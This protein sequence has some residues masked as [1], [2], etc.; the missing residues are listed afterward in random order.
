MNTNKFQAYCKANFLK[1]PDEETYNFQF[2]TGDIDRHMLLNVADDRMD[3]F[4]AKYY[5]FKVQ[6]GQKSM[7]LERP[8]PEFNILKI[9]IDLHHNPTPDD[10]R[11]GQLEHRY[12]HEMIKELATLYLQAVAELAPIPEGAKITVFE[13][14]HPRMK[15]KDGEKKMIKDGIHI[16]SGDIVG[17]N[18]LL[19][20]VYDRFIAMPEL[21]EVYKKFGNSESLENMVDRKVIS[22]TAWFPIGSGK[23]DD[24]SDFY[25]PTTTYSIRVMEG[26]EDEDLEDEPVKVILR[27]CELGMDMQQAIIHFSNAHKRPTIQPHDY[28][29]LQKLAGARTNTNNT[30]DGTSPLTLIERTQILNQYKHGKYR[31]VIDPEYIDHLLICLDRK[32]CRDYTQ[33]ANIGLCLYNISPY[34]YNM[35]V[36]WSKGASDKFDEDVCFRKWYLEFKNTA[37]KYSLGIDVLKQY[38]R[39]DNPVKY[40]ELTTTHKSIFLENMIKD[41][42]R[43]I[44]MGNRKWAMKA[45]EYIEIHCEWQIKCISTKQNTWYKFMGQQWT[46]DEGGNLLHRFLMGD[47][48][49]DIEKLYHACEDDISSIQ[50]DIKEMERQHAR[51]TNRN[52]MFSPDNDEF[53]ANTLSRRFATENGLNEQRSMEDILNEKKTKA[54]TLKIKEEEAKTMFKQAGNAM[55]YLEKKTNRATLISDLS[56]EFFDPEFYKNLDTNRMVFLCT[57]GVLDLET[58]QFRKGMPKD[59]STLN[60]GYNY[61]YDTESEEAQL[62]FAEIEECLDKIFP[63]LEV[64]NYVMNLYAEKLS[65]IVRREEFFIHTGSGKNGKSIFAFLLKHVFGQ[66]F[67]MT[68][69]TLFSQIRDD[70]DKPAPTIANIRGKRVIVS[71]EPKAEK[72]LQCDTIKRLTGGD[73]ITG[74]HL[75]KDPITFYPMCMW[76]MQCNDIPD[77][78]STDHGTWRRI[79]VINYPSR[80][81]DGKSEMLNDPEKYPHH[82]AEDSTIKDKLE[83]WAPYFLV[84]LFNRYQDLKKENFRSLS[85]EYIPTPVKEATERYKQIANVYELFAKEHTVDNPGYKQSVND[86]WAEFVRYTQSVNHPNKVSKK[87]FDVQIKRFMGD[88]RTIGRDLVFVDRTLRNQ[89]EPINSVSGSGSKAITSAAPPA[90]P[91]K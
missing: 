53:G 2:W 60:C 90:T 28:V 26:I 54:H 83:K 81:V 16:V 24:K 34:C 82:Y 11:S 31:D 50:K 4:W 70:P 1:K 29:N 76:N 13:K 56:N 91:S 77:M 55:N 46:E 7:L 25:K 41:L 17:S 9:D 84:M 27:K 36:Q 6:A 78:D 51:D 63:D 61:P 15:G 65:G 37:D 48:Y 67:Q 33:W 8:H 88:P 32:R 72:G 64:Q 12:N 30:P 57:N 49:N 22:T 38:A 80:F 68:D 10:L 69:P 73:P 59:I 62:I 44:G 3:E 43:G 89:G 85:D 79:H 58:C 47:F 71:S 52:D 86:V 35:W 19:H 20:A 66:Y 21:Q 74:R 23:P 40:K 39:S 42:N 87:Q 5:E 75:N 18:A 45:K 14:K